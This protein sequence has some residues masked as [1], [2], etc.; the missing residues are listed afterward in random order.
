MAFTFSHTRARAP[1]RYARSQRHLSCSLRSLY[2]RHTRARACACACVRAVDKND[3]TRARYYAG[4]FEEAALQR[5]KLS[6]SSSLFSF[7]TLRE[8]VNNNAC[9]FASTFYC[10]RAGY[11]S[12]LF[13]VGS[14]LRRRRRGWYLCVCT[15]LE[16]A[17]PPG[18][19]CLS[20]HF[21]RPL[22]DRATS[23]A[24]ATA[25]VFK[26]AATTE[27]EDLAVLDDN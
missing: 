13:A 8:V 16:S 18:G 3:H 12:Y 9:L 1:N 17:G 15:A 20:G 11:G 6:L 26:R 27:G 21:T 23:S 22:K 7:H 14:H 19:R 4:A 10:R 5:E 25:G 24:T 2:I